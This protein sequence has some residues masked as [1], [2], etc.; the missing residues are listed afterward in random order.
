MTRN[1]ETDSVKVGKYE[2]V[3]EYG[4]D[5]DQ[6]VSIF[7][8]RRHGTHWRSLTGD[9][10]VMALMHEI[11]DLRAAAKRGD[12]SDE[13]KVTLRQRC[14]AYAQRFLKKRPTE[15]DLLALVLVEI[16][17]RTTDSLQ[18]SKALVMYFGN[19]ADREEMIQAVHEVKPDMIAKRVP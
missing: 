3:H 8:A 4:T 7:Y 2:V 14:A 10:L 12:V 19:N 5:D 6:P 18:D 13:H 15:D 11:I 17:R 1:T 16:G 9:N